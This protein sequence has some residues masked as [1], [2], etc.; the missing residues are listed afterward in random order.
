MEVKYSLILI[1][2]DNSGRWRISI[3][4]S[5]VGRLQIAGDDFDKWGSICYI[6]L[7][8]SS[9][10]HTEKC[11]NIIFG[12]LQTVKSELCGSYGENM[13]LNLNVISKPC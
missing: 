5:F 7:L 6:R 8:S 2:D 10:I 3:L 4:Y 1:V 9:S 12:H 11:Q 13:F